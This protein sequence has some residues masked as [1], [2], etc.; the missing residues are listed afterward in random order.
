MHSKDNLNAL[1]NAYEQAL[2]DY[3]AA[4]APLGRRV[5][6]GTRPSTEEL[7]REAQ[8]QRA[9]EVARRQLLEALRRR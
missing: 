5:L 1:A 4:A 7:E 8:A 6:A 2:I 3:E 9:L